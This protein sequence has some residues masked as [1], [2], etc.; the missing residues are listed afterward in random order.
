MGAARAGQPSS[1][2]Q[3]QQ[4]QQQQA[5]PQAPA[6]SQKIKF[7]HAADGK[8]GEEAYFDRAGE[9]AEEQRQEQQLATASNA[10][11]QLHSH[12]VADEPSRTAAADANADTLAGG[13]FSTTTPAALEPKEPDF[14]PRVKKAVVP[15]EDDEEEELEGLLEHAAH[16]GVFKGKRKAAAIKL[17]VN[18]HVAAS[19]A[20]VATEPTSAEE[21]SEAKRLKS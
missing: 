9:T 19:A 12:A 7:A 2:Q 4:Q 1:Q 8:D 14:R 18:T 11:L 16:N 6:L 5:P 21:E 17:V 15:Y 10:P 13:G 20:G 3:L